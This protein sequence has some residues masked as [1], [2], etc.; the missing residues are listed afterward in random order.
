MLKLKMHSEAFL[1]AY[2]KEVS[3]KETH[4][5][6]VKNNTAKFLGKRTTVWRKKNV[7]QKRKKL[8]FLFCRHHGLPE[9]LC[10]PVH[11]E[12]G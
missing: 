3:W 7:S 6:Q 8:V 1:T 10:Q 11:D 4:L 5:I 9:F 12:R 2:R